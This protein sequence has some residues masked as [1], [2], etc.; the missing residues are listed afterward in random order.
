MEIHFCDLCNESVPDSDLA[1]GKA[2][3][4]KG[5]VVCAKCDALM[6]HAAPPAIE[7]AARAP[8]PV[9]Q[10]VHVAPAPPVTAPVVAH[11][12]VQPQPRSGA[13]V[14]VAVGLFSIALTAFAVWFLYDRA[15]ATRIAHERDLRALSTSE[16]A[17]AA[18]SDRRASEL[19][20][21][22]DALGTKLSA[23]IR[24]AQSAMTSGLERGSA[25]SSTALTKV[26]QFGREI[27]GMEESIALVR[28]HEAELRG[29]QQKFN[30]LSDELAA[31]GSVL[32][33]LEQSQRNQAAVQP[34]AHAPQAPWE[35]I[36][37]KLESA[38][39]MDRWTA[40]Q[41]LGETRDPAVADHL[42]PLLKDTDIFVRMATARVL[43]DLGAPRA[44]AA[45]IDAL[46]DPE[47]S[48]REA[49]YAALVAVTKRNL[50]FDYDAD[51]AERAKRVKAWRD[52]WKKEGGATG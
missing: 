44:T 16:S 47:P 11:H 27:A 13:L 40:V 31:L 17:Q 48:V 18:S 50:P 49:A 38:N 4:R 6:S 5:R 8:E 23:E 39:N 29:L 25:Q 28:R 22:I 45:L 32:A 26:E 36:L 51:P 35:G 41:Q 10:A 33:S 24:E 15:E 37:P 30:D 9:F 52:W 43:G 19:E 34:P 7:T 20:Q 21:R 1:A 12:N 42:L 2:F 46:E 3:M 14:G